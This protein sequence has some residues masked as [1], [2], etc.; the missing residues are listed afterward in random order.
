MSQLSIEI[1]YQD[2]DLTEILV[3]ANNGHF[4]GCTK[5]Y[6]TPDELIKFGNQIKGFPKKISQVE[7]REFGFT[8]ADQEKLDEIRKNQPEM[9]AYSTAYLCLSFYCIDNLG[10]PVVHVVFKED[11]WSKRETDAGTA[12]F[13]IMVEPAQ[14]DK[15]ADELIEMGSEKSGKAV[16]LG[17][18]GSK[19]NFV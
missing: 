15:F 1:V 4:S 19:D 14:I 7:K 10:H 11:V 9:G 8:Q 5:I 18:H 16:L 12:S 17:I 13:E 3:I 6:I 2:E